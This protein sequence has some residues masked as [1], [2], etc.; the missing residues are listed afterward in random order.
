MQIT[1]SGLGHR[2]GDRD[3]L[4]TGLDFT[5][6]A[7]DLV[8][9]VGPSGSG[10]STLLGIIAGHLKPAQGSVEKDTPGGVTW[11]L[12]APYGMARRTVIDHVAFPPIAAGAGR[13]AAEVTAHRALQTVGLAA[14]AHSDFGQLSGGEAQ[15]LMLARAIVSTQ[16]V[17]LVDEPTAQLDPASATSVIEVLGALAGLHKIVLV[18]THDERVAQACTR[19]IRLG[20]AG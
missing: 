9:L 2:F 17:I 13:S 8:A 14:V 10:K 6:T 20:R 7:G 19:T 12:Q 11:V 16:D 1:G 4:F 3:W 15:R 18:A 5:V